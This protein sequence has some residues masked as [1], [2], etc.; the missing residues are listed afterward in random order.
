M[1]HLKFN[2]SSQCHKTTILHIVFKNEKANCSLVSS[3]D[4]S[5]QAHVNYTWRQHSLV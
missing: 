1:T 4:E 5:M 3:N 2:L